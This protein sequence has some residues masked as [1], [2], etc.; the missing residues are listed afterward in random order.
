MSLTIVLM[1]TASSQTSTVLLTLPPLSDYLVDYRLDV[2]HQDA[3][4]VDFNGS[5]YRA[6]HRD[7]RCTS[8]RELVDRH[9]LNVADVVHANTYPPLEIIDEK[10]QPVC[11]SEGRPAERYAAVD[12]GHDGSTQVDDTAHSFGRAG[13]SRHL[14]RGNDLTKGIH[15]TC[16]CAPGQ[17]EHEKAARR[18]MRFLRDD[19]FRRK[20]DGVSHR[21]ETWSADPLLPE[22]RALPR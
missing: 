5:S 20:R 3:L 6:G 12:N 9:I 13:Q 14:L 7:F 19:I 8:C 10:N 22:G 1:N 21:I 11:A 17:L 4:A 16:E 15:V 2:Q 18:D